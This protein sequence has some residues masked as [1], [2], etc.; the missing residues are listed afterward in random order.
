MQNDVETGGSTILFAACE[1]IVVRPCCLNLCNYNLEYLCQH[2]VT[3][4]FL[5]AII[6]LLIVLLQF[7]KF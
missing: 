4:R 1:P 2:V 3:Y 5:S 6:Y 7:N